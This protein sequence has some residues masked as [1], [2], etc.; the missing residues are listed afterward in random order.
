[1]RPVPVRRLLIMH[2]GDNQREGPAVRGGQNASSRTHPRV[3]L[4]AKPSLPKR[5]NCGCSAGNGGTPFLF[6]QWLAQSDFEFGWYVEEDVVFT[7]H[8]SDIF[9]LRI[10]RVRG[11]SPGV[12]QDL[13]AHVTRAPP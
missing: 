13:V 7:G 5:L 10:K 12:K 4:V 11:T 2:G 6:M 1:M 8:W 9:K 3:H